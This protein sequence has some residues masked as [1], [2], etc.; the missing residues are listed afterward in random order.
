MVVITGHPLPRVEAPVIFTLAG[1]HGVVAEGVSAY[2][3][4]VTAQMVENFARGGAAVNVLARQVGARV[5]VRDLGVAARLLAYAGVVERG[6]SP[7]ARQ[8][9]EGAGDDPRGQA[10]AAIAVGAALVDDGR[11]R[12]ASDRGDGD[13]QH[14]CGECPHRR[15]HRRGPGRRHRTRH[16][17]DDDV[18]VR[19]VEVVRRALAV[20][21]PDPG[22]P[23]GVLAA[24]GGLEIAGLVGV[25]PG[26]EPPAASPS[27]STGS[28]RR[29]R[30]WWPRAAP[31]AGGEYLI[32][33]HRSVEPGHAHLLQALG[34]APYLDL[35]MRLG[36]G[37]GAALRN[38]PPSGGAR[39]LRGDGDVQG[40]RCVGAP[41]V[42][43]SGRGAAEA[44]VVSRPAT[45]R[46]ARETSALD[47]RS[48]ARAGLPS[49]RG[50][51]RAP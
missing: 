26:G 5:V 50:G 31:P 3:Q 11:R 44:L 46:P 7:P 39:L 19:K 2:P 51:R 23:L 1:D 6:R 45:R 8:P 37:T 22:D 24:V 25:R 41:A 4:A 30:R 21:R 40:G 20:N 12:T 32:A 49:F 18:R 10:L 48:G 16:G 35:G 17:L 15:A 28:S 43:R 33:S 47:R 34:L 27:C 13:R 9:H 14:D 42:S 29:V 38:R 36:E